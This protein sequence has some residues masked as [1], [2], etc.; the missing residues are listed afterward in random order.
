MKM[1]APYCGIVYDM[2]SGRHIWLNHDYI[3]LRYFDFHID[4]DEYT[5]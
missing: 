5:I 1:K 3:N 2:V 4:F